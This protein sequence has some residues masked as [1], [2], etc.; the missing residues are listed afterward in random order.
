M[1]YIDYLNRFNQWLKSNY[2]PGNARLLYY[3]MLSVFNEAGWPAFIQVDN[4]RLMFMVD[5]K[6]E[7]VA[8]SARDSLVGSG[9]IVYSKGKKRNPNKY[10]L[11]NFTIQKVSEC[12]SVSDSECDSVSGSVSVQKTVS[13]IKTKKKNKIT[14]LPPF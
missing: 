5:T 10:R 3:S 12:D 11:T 4:L 9:F 2:L 14:P 8:I 1:T 13:H 7:R 6:T